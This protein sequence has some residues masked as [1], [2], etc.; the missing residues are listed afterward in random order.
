MSSPDWLDN[1]A[2]AAI[3]NDLLERTTVRRPGPGVENV[4]LARLLRRM[5]QSVDSLV[6]LVTIQPNN[7][8][9]GATILRT[10]YDAHLQLLYILKSP[11][12]RAE[13]YVDFYWVEF[14]KQ[15]A[16]I[17]CVNHEAFKAMRVNTN[18]AKMRREAE[19]ELAAVRANYPDNSNHRFRGREKATRQTWYEGSLRTLAKAVGYES[20]YQIVMASLHPIVHSSSF[21]VKGPHT[22]GP[23]VLCHTAWCLLFRCLGKTAEHLAVEIPERVRR[24]ILGTAYGHL[25]DA[26]EETLK[27][28]R[29]ME[30]G[31]GVE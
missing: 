29:E 6:T 16:L 10:I 13:L 15:N 7:G 31:D 8:A 3:A 21:G 5:M 19:R 17:N 25:F 4:A 23:N 9:D 2:F 22:I 27:M 11:R 20:E 30:S 14:A 26:D 18:I 12:A 28:I 24:D 1:I